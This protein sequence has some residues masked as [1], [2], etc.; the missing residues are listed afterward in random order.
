MGYT[1]T[2]PR[3]VSQP[4]TQGGILQQ[5]RTA[6]REH[7]FANAESLMDQHIELADWSYEREEIARLQEGHAA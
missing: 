6:I 7:R 3:A 5:V 2:L 1:A 4:P